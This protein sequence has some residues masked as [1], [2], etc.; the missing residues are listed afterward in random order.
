M[1]KV[2]YSEGF[3]D[4][5]TETNLSSA[6]V[7][8]PH[9]MKLVAPRSVA[10]IGCGEGIWLKAFIEAGVSEV[11]GVD[12]EWVQKERLQFPAESFRTADLEEPVV[13]D[14]KYDLSV[15]LEVGEHLSDEASDI[16]VASLTNAA[17]AVLFSA[18]IPLQGGSHHVNEQW[19][20]YW[21]EKFKARGYMPVDC[22]RRHI[23]NDKKVSFFYAQNIFIFVKK[24]SLSQYPKL[25]AEV[26]A[27]NS[28]ALPLVHP[29]MYLYYAERWRSIVPFLG[30]FPP[31]FLHAVKRLLGKGRS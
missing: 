15:C 25:Q 8:V 5:M 28:N 10:D 21:E 14:K 27:G 4:E 2:S 26:E 19:P 24:E 3:F 20:S 29:H 12:G 6:R 17:P 30:K 31:S 13:L 22:I 23:W 11:Q 16:L 18:A 1:A 9:I 7:V